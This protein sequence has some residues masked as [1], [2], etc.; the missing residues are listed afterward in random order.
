MVIRVVVL[1]LFSFS[2]SLKAQGIEPLTSNEIF[3]NKDTL[4]VRY[5][6]ANDG[7]QVEI[8]NSKKDTVFIFSTYLEKKFFSSKY[9]HRIDFH[10][11]IYKIS[12]TPV[13]PLLYTKRSDLLK[14]DASDWV[15]GN[16]NL[17]SFKEL[18]PNTKM[19]IQINYIDLFKN[20][21]KYTENVVGDF[22]S[23]KIA[24]TDDIATLSTRDIGKRKFKL[25]VEFAI[26]DKVDL[27]TTESAYY[28]RRKEFLEQAKSFDIISIP[29][30]LK[31]YTHPFFDK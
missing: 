13:I 4:F 2:L 1:V 15:L 26:Y 20:Q 10:E 12:F 14:I 8:V 3:L 25:K 22:D 31:N 18:L 19:V 29:L 11:S 30:K 21:D 16:Q 17:Y 28:L 6:E 24:G 7:L 23:K 27:L 5:K 9:L